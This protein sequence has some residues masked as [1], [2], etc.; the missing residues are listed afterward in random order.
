MSKS[1]KVA[2]TLPADTFRALERARKR[3]RLNRSEAIQQ[4]VAFWLAAREGDP[5]V[6]EYIRG[7]L[8]VPDDP[9]EQSAMVEAW[10]AGQEAED[11]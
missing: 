8:A 1:A 4:A 7:Y 5:R 11:W 3:L 10:A 2:I 6:E 9:R